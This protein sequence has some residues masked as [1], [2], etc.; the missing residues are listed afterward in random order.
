MSTESDR[1]RTIFQWLSQHSLGKLTLALTL[2]WFGLG[3]WRWWTCRQRKTPLDLPL[4]L[5][6]LLAIA[7]PVM[8]LNG[9]QSGLTRLDAELSGLSGLEPWEGLRALTLIRHAVSGFW[10][11]STPLLSAGT[12]SLICSI[13]LGFCHSVWS[14][15][16]FWVCRHNRPSELQQ[17]RDELASLRRLLEEQKGRPELAERPQLPL[18][19]T[20]S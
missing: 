14:F 2:V 15:D 13:F 18:S 12:A 7:S 9:I 17:I 11:W 4:L 5:P 10:L 19:S 6:L 16:L 8:M 20:A 3:C 1:M